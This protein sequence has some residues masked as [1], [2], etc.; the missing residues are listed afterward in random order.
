[1]RITIDTREDSAAD[2]GRAIEL[3]QRIVEQRRGA[4]GP[5]D[6]PADE[7]SNRGFVS[8]FG[9]MEAAQAPPSPVPAAQSDDGDGTPEPDDIPELETY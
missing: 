7:S 8:M 1:M 6:L 3:L 4:D 9:G 2:I 5:G